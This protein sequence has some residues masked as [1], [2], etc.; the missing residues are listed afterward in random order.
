MSRNKKL[1][2]GIESIERQIEFHKAK[3]EEARSAGDMG[4]VYYFDK[5]IGQMIE[6][7]EKK[8]RQLGN[9]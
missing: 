9:V 2:K 5:E 4:L 1:R 8:K 7:R 3:R 6:D